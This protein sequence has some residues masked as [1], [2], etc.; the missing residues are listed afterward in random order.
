[1]LEHYFSQEDIQFD[2]LQ[3]ENNVQEMGDATARYMQLIIIMGI[4]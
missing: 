4:T 1:M 2:A 3:S